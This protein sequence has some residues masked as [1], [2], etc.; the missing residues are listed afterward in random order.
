[1]SPKNFIKFSFRNSLRNNIC[2]FQP[3]A[4]QDSAE[5]IYDA[6]P[7]NFGTDRLQL[8]EYVGVVGS[9]I[10]MVFGSNEFFHLPRWP[11]RRG[12]K[13]FA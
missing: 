5:S 9:E 11:S 7:A 4:D 10:V 6:I 13:Y 8:F 12:N 3:V 2:S 1:M